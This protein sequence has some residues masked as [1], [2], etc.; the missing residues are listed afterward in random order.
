MKT[1]EQRQCFLMSP[2]QWGR[3]GGYSCTWIRLN[4]YFSIIYFI[5]YT[6]G[7]TPN[8][9]RSRK[10]RGAQRSREFAFGSTDFPVPENLFFPALVSN[11]WYTYFVRTY[12]QLYQTRILSKL[13]SVEVFSCCRKLWRSSII[14]RHFCTNIRNCRNIIVSRRTT[15]DISLSH[16]KFFQSWISIVS[17]NKTQPWSFSF[18]K[19]ANCKR[20]NEIEIRVGQNQWKALDKIIFVASNF[21]DEGW[22]S[23]CFS[24]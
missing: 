20:K 7:Y 16:R 3:P 23:S 1:P 24:W 18:T 6:P 15:L 21:D 10:L 13:H 12:L 11:L 4:I 19:I 8:V 14:I 17:C 22:N 9:T 2:C 5:C